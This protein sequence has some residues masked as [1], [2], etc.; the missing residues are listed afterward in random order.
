MEVITVTSQ[1]QDAAKFISNFSNSIRLSDN[2]EVGLLK[3]AHPPTMN[4]TNINNKMFIHNKEKDAIA[5]LEIPAGFYETTH[6]VVQ[7]MEKS[8]SNY[9]VTRDDYSGAHQPIAVETPRDV[10]TSAT[11]RYGTRNATTADNSRVVLELT[12]K[13]SF[14]LTKEEYQSL[15]IL[16]F[17]DFRIGNLATRGL[18]VN[19]Y[20]LESIDQIGFVYSSIVSNSLIDYRV[21][22]LLDTVVIKSHKNGHHLFEVQNPVFHEVSAASFIDISFEIRDVNGDIIKFHGDLPTILTLG[23]RKRQ[24]LSI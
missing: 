3:I 5:I 16:H 2:Y 4:I 1:G 6:D 24:N 23:I 18:V 22:R 19:N 17:L 12:D 8:L 15:N 21:S 11:I 9:N 14:F 13:K 7:A 10:I 20:D